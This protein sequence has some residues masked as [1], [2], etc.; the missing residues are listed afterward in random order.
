MLTS[1]WLLYHLPGSDIV[2]YELVKI[3]YFL[4]I[5]NSCIIKNRIYNKY[6]KVKNKIIKNKKNKIIK[7]I[8]IIKK[9]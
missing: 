6:E 5:E 8:K 4:L 1:M 7:I 3:T 2:M 9:N